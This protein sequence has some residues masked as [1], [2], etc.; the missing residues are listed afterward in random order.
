MMRVRW[1]YLVLFCALAAC[2]KTRPRLVVEPGGYVRDV[3]TRSV[4]VEHEDLAPGSLAFDDAVDLQVVI[5]ETHVL[6]LPAMEVGG[7]ILGE[8]IAEVRFALVSPEPTPEAAH[9]HLVR[10]VALLGQVGITPNVPVPSTPAELA[11]LRDAGVRLRFT[12]DEPPAA[13]YSVDLKVGW[14]VG[15]R[16]GDSRAYAQ[17]GFVANDFVPV[18][19]RRDQP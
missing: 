1:W 7:V 18:D 5:D 9:A 3:L 16:E 13:A 6:A 8:Q 14:Y 15:H 11:A 2:V 10:A 4:G 12:F 19:P 17:F